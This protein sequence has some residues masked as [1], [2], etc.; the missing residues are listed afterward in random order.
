MGRIGAPFGIK[1][2][3][4]IQPYTESL[5]SLIDY[6]VWQINQG[7]AWQD[8]EV[9]EAAVH[10]DGVIAKLLGIEDRDQAF[11][12][13]GKEIAVN[14]E[15][16]PEPAANEYYWN[17]LIGMTVFNREGVELGQ[18]TGLMETGS[19]DVLVIKGERERLIPFADAYVAHVDQLDRRIEVNWEPDW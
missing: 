6:D 3:I 5:D 12:L 10:G 18:V 16:L 19:H 11:A 2:W 14:R 9:E 17:D 8:F 13:R 15:Q 7:A 1:G 4:K